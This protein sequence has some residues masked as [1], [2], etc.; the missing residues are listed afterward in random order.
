MRL[1]EVITKH[2]RPSTFTTSCFREAAHFCQWTLK[3]CNSQNLSKKRGLKDFNYLCLVVKSCF[4]ACE[5]VQKLLKLRTTYYNLSLS[6][7]TPTVLQWI[8]KFTKE[9]DWDVTSEYL[10]L[11]EIQWLLKQNINMLSLHPSY[12]WNLA[13]CNDALPV[14]R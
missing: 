8:S 9:N 7:H 13:N 6:P 5:F 10:H 4:I 12:F 11:S 3:T 14:A 1:S 2:I